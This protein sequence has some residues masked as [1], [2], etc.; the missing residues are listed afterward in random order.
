[1]PKTKATLIKASGVTQVE[2]SAL[3][4]R[5]SAIEGKAPAYTLYITDGQGMAFAHLTLPRNLLYEF[6]RAIRQLAG[7]GELPVEAQV[8]PTS[9]LAYSCISTQPLLTHSFITVSC[10]SV[11]NKG[12]QH[13]AA[14]CHFSEEAIPRVIFSSPPA[15]DPSDHCPDHYAQDI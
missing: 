13:S 3:F 5:S 12:F 15:G 11:Q 4:R 9:W 7:F 1:M 10:R 2:S 6:G 14:C 8:E